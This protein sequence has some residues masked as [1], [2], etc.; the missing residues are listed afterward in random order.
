MILYK[1]EGSQLS[2]KVPAYELYLTC[3]YVFFNLSYDGFQHK[4]KHVAI[5]KI[6]WIRKTN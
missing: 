1:C 6:M 5:N 4:L 3:L 2:G